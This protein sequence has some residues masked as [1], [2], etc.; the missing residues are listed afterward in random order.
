MATGI[1]KKRIY[2]VAKKYYQK[3]DLRDE[4]CEIDTFKTS[5]CG[6]SSF[7]NINY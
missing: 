2:S 5:F 1:A 4:K 7:D 3:C 6:T